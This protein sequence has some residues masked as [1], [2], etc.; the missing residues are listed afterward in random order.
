MVTLSHIIPAA[1]VYI[2]VKVV[3]LLF[4]HAWWYIYKAWEMCKPYL[5]SKLIIITRPSQVS[6]TEVGSYFQ[7][8]MLQSFLWLID[9][10]ANLGLK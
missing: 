10:T 5:N 9:K 7:E 2:Q 1:F 8:I 4:M 3:R 6:C